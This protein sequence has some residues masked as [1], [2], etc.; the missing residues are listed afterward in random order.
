[1][2]AVRLMA[3]T[4]TMVM[5]KIEEED[6]EYGGKNTESIVSSAEPPTFRR[7]RLQTETDVITAPATCECKHAAKFA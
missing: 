2:L 4:M 7:H 5:I 1:M 6:E 3:V